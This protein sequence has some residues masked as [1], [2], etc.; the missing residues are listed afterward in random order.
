VATV[1][2]NHFAIH[3]FAKKAPAIGNWQLEIGN[4]Y[5]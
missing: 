2:Q 1:R 5:V 4:T 3:H